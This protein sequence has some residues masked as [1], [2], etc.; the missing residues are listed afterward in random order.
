[1]RISHTRKEERRYRYYVSTAVLDG[2]GKPGSLRRVSAGI[3]DRAVVDAVTPLL[4]SHWNHGDVHQLRVAA[5]VRQ[6]DVSA[7]K[8][9]T[10]VDADAVDECAISL[11][12]IARKGGDLT[13]EHP[14][15]LAR[16]RN[17]MT[18]ISAERGAAR[19][20]RTLLG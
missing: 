6:I 12:T 2:Q 1:M 3:L 10:T 19:P 20:D 4:A 7:N 18:I 15:A 13:F 17:T 8:L 9:R 5:A 11:K 16:P 14:V